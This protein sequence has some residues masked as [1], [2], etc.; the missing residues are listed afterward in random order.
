MRP[1]SFAAEP[2]Q[3]LTERQKIHRN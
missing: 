1:P 3:S 2:K